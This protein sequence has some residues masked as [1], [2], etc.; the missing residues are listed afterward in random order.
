[1]AQRRKRRKTPRRRGRGSAFGRGSSAARSVH[2]QTALTPAELEALSARALSDPSI[3]LYAELAGALATAGRFDD[4]LDAY[5]HALNLGEPGSQLHADMGRLLMNIGRQSEAEAQ[6]RAAIAIDP[7]CAAAVMDLCWCLR[8]LQRAD[9]AVAAGR[10]AV[11]LTDYSIAKYYLAFALLT[12]DRPDEALL[13]CDA[14]LAANARDARA[15]ALKVTALDAS[16]SRD[17]AR[18][19][20]SFEQ[21]I[22]VVDIDAPP[23][24]TN[25]TEFNRALVEQV[26]QTSGRPGD[27]TQTIDLFA[28]PTGAAAALGKI[29]NEIIG[30]Y[31]A[32]LPTDP[33]HPF[34][35]K[36][37]TQWT[38]DGWGTRLLSAPHQEHHFHQHGWVSG[39]YYARL[40]P[41]V[42]TP[43][44]GTSGCLEFCRFHQYG[45][46]EV[47]SE[48]MVLP[49]TEGM[50]VLFPSYFYH[51]VC[52]FEHDEQRISIAFN[53]T[54]R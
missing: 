30:E 23:E 34:L 45:E 42:G 16:Q 10:E 46:A 26:L 51:R 47:N 4:A 1:M 39:V 8:R 13:V 40:P 6:L 15:L 31:L 17:A 11:A 37:P 3:I 38:L 54:V 9:E 24:F 20:A 27:D 21:L 18:R 41:F 29:I 22:G 19:L 50:M 25:L 52:P 36:K 12:A 32:A 43:E 7:R 28:Q 5:Q 53:A 14:M 44:A 2:Q 33:A 49:P 48:F 35:Q